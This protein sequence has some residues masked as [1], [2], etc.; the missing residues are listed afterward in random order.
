MLDF[1]K[2]WGLKEVSRHPTTHKPMAWWRSLM[3]PYRGKLHIVELADIT[4]NIN[5]TG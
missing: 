1:V 4:H 2:H 5:A 3:A